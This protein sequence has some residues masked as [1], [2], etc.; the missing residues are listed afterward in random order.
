M[1]TPDQLPAAIS[2]AIA[3]FERRRRLVLVLRGVGEAAVVQVG[4]LIVVAAVDQF[5]HPAL[6]TRVVLSSTAWLAGGA[7]LVWRGL[8]P[9]L[10]RRDPLASA[11]A[12]ERAA[13]GTLAERL[14]SALQLTATPAVGVSV[15]MINRTVA[16]AAQAAATL[17]PVHLVSS[18][19]ARRALFAGS[20]AVA[21]LGLACLSP[22]L[23]A[24]AARAAWPL[25]GVGR[26]SGYV[27]SVLPGD[28][29]IAQGARFALSAEISPAPGS[30]LAVLRWDDGL[31]QE[32][33]L[34]GDP[35]GNAFRLDLPA[36]TQG[37]A[38]QVRAGNGE[39]RTYRVA[40][41]QPPV[42]RSLTV[43]VRPPAYTGLPPRTQD[44]GD[45]EVVAGSVV[46]LQAVFAG[47]AVAAAALV[48]EGRDDQALV[49]TGDGAGGATE[50]IPAATQSYGLRL[51]GASGVRAEPPQRW[52]VTVRPDGAPTTALSAAG[53]ASGL[54]GAD[55]VLALAC[56]AGDDLGLR[57]LDLVIADDRGEI[58]RRPLLER[59][60]DGGP[61]VVERAAEVDLGA[62]ALGIGD[63]LQLTLEAEDL[64][65][66]RSVSEP[67][68]VTVSG[69][70]ESRAAAWAEALHPE[71]AALD[72]Q[73]TVLR[74][75]EKAWMTLARSHR[76]EDPSAQRGDALLVAARCDEATA[77]CAA[78]A[79]RVY[80]QAAASRLPSAP[81][82]LAVADALGRW[83]GVQR[84]IL[85]KV[86][87][88]LDE[89]A[90][91]SE[92]LLRCRDLS[93]HALVGLGDLR[94]ALGLQ[95]ACL[96]AEGLVGSCDAAQ[97]RMMRAV[98]VLRGR[99]VWREKGTRP[100][101]AG[102]VFAGVELA[103]V[104]LREASG[105]PDLSMAPGGRSSDWSARWRGELHVEA[106]G[107][108]EFVCTADDGVRL[109]LD[110]EAILP[111]TAWAN[112][113]ATAHHGR[114]RLSAGW[115]R[116][117]LEYFQ[118]GG[119]AK[120]AVTWGLVGGPSTELELAHTRHAAVA[121][122]AALA[123]A[124]ASASPVTGARALARLVQACTAIAGTPAVIRR[125]GEDAGRDGLQRLAERSEPD[126]ARCAGV[127][128]SAEQLRSNDLVELERSVSALVAAARRARDE[129]EQ[130]AASDAVARPSRPLADERSLAR[131]L[132][133]RGEAMRRLARDL[134][135]S[136]LAAAD[137]REGAAA[138]ATLAVLAERIAERRQ[139]LAE[140]AASDGATVGERA[141]ALTARVQMSNEVAAAVHEVRTELASPTPDP[142][143]QGERLAKAAE[144]LDL[145]LERSEQAV[146]QADAARQAQRVA[147]AR[148]EALAVSAAER[149]ADAPAA[150]AARMR[151]ARTLAEAAAAERAAGD[152][153]DAAQLEAAAASTD[154]HMLAKALAAIESAD[155]PPAL[156]AQAARHLAKVAKELSEGP[157]ATAADELRVAALELAV[158][159]E[160]QRQQKQPE[161][162]AAF[163]RLA[164]QVAAAALA[165]DAERVA[166]LAREVDAIRAGDTAARAR[167]LA[168]PAAPTQAAA[169]R[170]ARLVESAEA[171][172]RDAKQRDPAASEL[173]AA[174]EGAVAVASGE[175]EPA[176]ATT[177]ERER[178]A[179]ELDRLV[180]QERQ[181]S[182]AEAAARA[183][184]AAHGRAA[185]DLAEAIAGEA[186]A[187]TVAGADPAADRLRAALAAV[188][189]R[190]PAQAQAARARAQRADQPAAAT[191]TPDLARDAAAA[192]AAIE[193]DLGAPLAEAWSA[194]S[195]TDP[196]AS[197]LTPTVALAGRLAE[198][199]AGERESAARLDRV[200]ARREA[201]QAA[202][203]RSL[204]TAAQTAPVVAEV[205]AADPEQPVG[206]PSDAADDS[207]A[208]AATDATASTPASATAAVDAAAAKV[209]QN[210]ADGAQAAASAA[211]RQ[212]EAKAADAA[213]STDPESATTRQAE[214]VRAHAVAVERQAA[215]LA[216][217][218]AALA[219]PALAADPAL[220][221][222]AAANLAEAARSAR[223]LD[224]L[225]AAGAPSATGQ[226]SDQA[227]AAH[228]ALAKATAGAAAAATR[229]AAALRAEDVS[230]STG[231]VAR[232]PGDAPTASAPAASPSATPAATR[233]AAAAALAAL[234]AQT[235]QAS[236]WQSAADGLA[237][238]AAQSRLSALAMAAGMPTSPAD[239][240]PTPPGSQAGSGV[241][242]V[243]STSNA[244][245]ASPAGDG[246]PGGEAGEGNATAVVGSDGAEWGRSRGNLRGDVMASGIE[247]F[248]E[249]QQEAIRAYFRRLGEDR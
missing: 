1:T 202:L 40:L 139:Q 155:A 211:A 150:A 50:F 73:A 93:E 165:P 71:L 88:A 219:A 132:I 196:A 213:R 46:A 156:D 31:E 102:S 42:L 69:G 244:G 114:R 62:Y 86:G 90:A 109:H 223:A 230:A 200:L 208:P 80:A 33:A 95:V 84:G 183:E 52:L 180:A 4:A 2:D 20:L 206:S 10:A 116:F 178:Q 34:G 231:A 176:P 205:L 111:T 121:V 104:A 11:H 159:G 148:R 204:A 55:E 61:R 147:G 143:Q 217:Q 112:Q 125:M 189:D 39:S 232:T 224:A 122:D 13:G 108:Y 23:A 193:N 242:S 166:A 228:A 97:A 236:A 94:Q 162:G 25:A 191:P 67:L 68:A 171:A 66:L 188:A 96:R 45:I 119:D 177:L 103:G 106:D 182:A 167:A 249:E 89:P 186:R 247:T 8:V 29:E 65:G 130:S 151:L 145:A 234:Q 56:Q 78:I 137:R 27:I 199:A 207:A 194:A 24:L 158:E 120:L 198:L 214:A 246:Q 14:S 144:R 126:G 215:A 70:D 32:L 44:G 237:A 222:H 57:R 30:A 113:G 63:R 170:L 28:A 233:Q 128:A 142:R 172:S 60:P 92:A 127:A 101:L 174:A 115:H 134:S 163:G 36:V 179:A 17:D 100:G 187:T 16:L 85:S 49:V 181:L 38:Y 74:Q 245:R 161:V 123:R 149:A 210:R 75:A 105:L 201:N 3:A 53:L 209:A 168:A 12:L 239:S 241:A 9:A 131:E 164:D 91:G 240:G 169:E 43:G 221:A 22:T 153:G 238:A 138:E 7:V 212:A 21:A 82:V 47:E 140:R 98:P 235:D 220:A 64:G 135:S 227:A 18:R 175:A 48:R 117:Q 146:A 184:H 141:H 83:A 6:A 226:A 59:L 154:T 243:P 192:A 110:G 218:L 99:F 81:R 77:A 197:E 229:A 160:R 124:M 185:A 58:E 15:W 72:A 195:A 35:A 248:G 152:H 118:G 19:P 107:E 37:F 157:A 173:A 129:L 54:V 133:H 41:R 76:S 87:A 51:V 5:A 79:A 216:A 225:P 190:L 136:D 26:P 203:E